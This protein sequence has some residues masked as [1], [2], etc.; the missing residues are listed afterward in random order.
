MSLAGD[1]RP[2]GSET[3]TQTTLPLGADRTANRG[4]GIGA[5]H[6]TPLATTQPARKLPEALREAFDQVR[7]VIA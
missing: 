1:A 6:P 4:H 2:R 5:G 7:R 3:P